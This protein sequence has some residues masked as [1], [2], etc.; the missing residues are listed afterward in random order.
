MPG[1]KEHFPRKI[2]YDSFMVK[3]GTDWNVLSLKYI[4]VCLYHLSG[5]DDHLDPNLE[6][7]VLRN[8]FEWKYTFE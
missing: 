1:S 4:G 6:I 5:G 2:V 7:I 3:I 8:E